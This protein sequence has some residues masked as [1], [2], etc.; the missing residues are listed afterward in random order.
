MADPLLRVSGLSKSFGNVQ[1]LQDIDLTLEAGSIHGVVGPNGAGK[2]TLL[3]IM[4][5]YLLPN[6]GTV[7]LD[8]R[9]ITSLTPQLRVPLGVVRTFQNIRLFAGLTVLENVMLGQHTR[10]RT[11]W[12]SLLPFK[13]ADDRRLLAEARSSL[14]LFELTPYAN[15]RV[16]ELPYGVQKQLEMARAMATQP[17]V[18]LLDEPAAGMTAPARVSLTS[19]IRQVRDEGVSVIVVE[20]DMDVI[21][22][23]CDTV[24]VLNFGRKI[25]AGVPADVLASPEVRTAYL[26]T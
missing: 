22:R 13:T 17:R 2:T 10:A 3:S 9:D 14:D 5:G 1:A 7:E 25:S 8:G 24:T 15:R 4:S 19:R 16:S 6:Q 18:L 23:A 11:G 21:A 26:G 20:H 12:T